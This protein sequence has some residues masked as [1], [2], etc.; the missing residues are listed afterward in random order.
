MGDK[1][2]SY[3]PLATSN[4]PCNTQPT[5][6][7]PDNSLWCVFFLLSIC[8]VGILPLIV[9]IIW[10]CCSANFQLWALQRPD[11]CLVRIIYPL[12]LMLE[13]LGF[14]GSVQPIIPTWRKQYDR[15][16]NNFCATGQVWLGSWDDVSKAVEGPQAR[17][18]RLGEHPLIGSKLPDTKTRCVF[19]LSLSNKPYGLGLH[20]AI[21]A[22]LDETLFK[23]RAFEDRKMDA[24]AE[25]LFAG[26]VEEYKT[27]PNT[28]AGSFFMD[29]TIGLKRFLTKYLHYVIFG[30]KSEDANPADFDVLLKFEQGQT[31]IAYWMWPLGKPD[32]SKEIETITNLYLTSPA[33]KDFRSKAEHFNLTQREIANL[34]C[35]I[36]RFA[37]VQGTNLQSTVVMT[38]YNEHW[39]KLDLD[40]DNQLERYIAECGRLSGGVTVSSRVATEDFTCTI[41]GSSYKFPKGTN[42]AIPL[43]I[44]QIDKTFWGPDA[45]QFNH[46]RDKLLDNALMFNGVGV[47]NARGLRVCPGQ[48]LAMYTMKEL[49]KRCGKVRRMRMGA[50]VHIGK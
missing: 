21:R 47:T 39:D 12:L 1:G 34:M 11:N 33:L 16:G 41:A 4:Q 38:L 5:V 49:L 15:Y 42:I 17:T 10:I 40:S 43:C 9:V 2:A 25:R 50:T 37:G 22:C 29:E 23:T 31:P 32:M 36:M 6:G 19:L 14:G 8:T 35:A 18:N 7:V 26:V 27:L 30:L 44:G 28:A 48:D 46:N 24:Y 13:S 45:E 3:E 20:E